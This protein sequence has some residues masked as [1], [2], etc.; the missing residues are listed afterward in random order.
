MVNKVVIS[1]Y[2]GYDNIGDEAI[3]EAMLYDFKSFLSPEKIIV[4][5]NNPGCVLKQGIKSYSSRSIIENIKAI[6]NADLFIS[7]GGSLINDWNTLSLLVYLSRLI[8]AT[9]FCKRSMIYAQGIGPLRNNISQNVSRWVLNRVNL[10]TVRDEDSKELLYK[11]NVKK[12]VYV[13]SDPVFTLKPIKDAK[14][15][16][17]LEVEGIDYSKQLIIITIRPLLGKKCAV[18]FKETIASF[19]DYLI[20]KKFQV[21]FIQFQP[22][23]DKDIINETIDLVRSKDKVKIISGYNPRETMSIIGKANMVIGM[24]LHSLIFASIMGIPII[25]IIYDPKVKN[26]LKTIDQLNN[27]FYTQNIE[28][29]KLI[30]M[31]EELWTDKRKTGQNIKHRTLELENKA[32]I[33]I[34]LMKKILEEVE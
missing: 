25:G 10:I 13:T 3:L 15:N 17:I 4:L 9:I 7:G 22:N 12:P 31:F 16:E 29:S 20:D 28:L 6:Y 18:N 26:F 5:S 34:E 27:S 2:Y 24:R 30:E 21:A 33:N 8:F 19:I 23:Y 32:L 1:G 14:I 11:M